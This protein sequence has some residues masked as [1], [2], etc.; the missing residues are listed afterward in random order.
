MWLKQWNL[1]FGQVENFLGERENMGYQHFLLFQKC[2]QKPSSRVVKTWDC[3]VKSQGLK[4]FL[5]PL[6][7]C[8]FYILPNLKNCIQQFQIWWKWLKILQRVGKHCEKRRNC[9]L[10]A[11]SPF[12]TVFSKD[13]S[14]RYIKTRGLLEKHLTWAV[15]LTTAVV[16]AGSTDQDHIT[17]TIS[18][19]FIY[20]IS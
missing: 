15:S 20:T 8:K 13:M 18:L 17:S 5:N 2:F 9:S 12:P 16:T 1:F 6:Q 11:I 3:V 10:W 19:I 7:N 4:C 14:S